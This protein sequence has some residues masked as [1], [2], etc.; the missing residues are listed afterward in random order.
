M[1]TFKQIGVVSGG[2]TYCGDTNV[3]DYYV[4]VDHP[5]ISSFISG[6]ELDPKGKNNASKTN[7]TSKASKT[8]I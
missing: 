6:E 5:E 1:N 4:R 7:Q 3:P 8:Y 2:I